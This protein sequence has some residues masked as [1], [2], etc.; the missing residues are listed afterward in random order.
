MR[1]SHKAGLHAEG[2]MHDKASSIYAV[3]CVLDASECEC[4]LGAAEQAYGL[5]TSR[6]A[7]YGEADRAHGRCECN[8]ERAAA[9]LWGQTG[10]EDAL[11]AVLPAELCG[12]RLQ[13]LSRRLR[14]Y[15]YDGARC[16]HFGRHVDGSERA[17]GG[18]SEFTPDA[19]GQTRFFGSRRGEV[20]AEMAAEAGAALVFRHGYD[21]CL[22]HE[23]VPVERGV[24]VVLR[25][26]VVYA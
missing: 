2:P 13:G 12:R 9:A 23:S 4:L 15:R 22:E 26:D 16:E 14:L 7:A 3:R 18:V 6:G 10:L 24:K 11:R 1:L 17:D 19:G 25:S 20:V 5:A 21:K 8:D